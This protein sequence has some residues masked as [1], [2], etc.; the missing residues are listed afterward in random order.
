MGRMDRK[1]AE[2]EAGTRF[3]AAMSAIRSAWAE[4]HTPEGE[5][6]SVDGVVTP[7]AMAF[8]E[9]YCACLRAREDLD[10]SP[11]SSP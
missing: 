9:G 5:P 7:K 2:A 3:D 4:L 1:L 11:D 8:F 6:F 10:E